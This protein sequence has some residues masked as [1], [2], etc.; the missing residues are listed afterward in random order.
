MPD[1]R[2][3]LCPVSRGVTTGIRPYA[4]CQTARVCTSIV[5]ALLLMVHVQC[6]E[7]VVSC[8]PYWRLSDYR[9]STVCL[10]ETAG[11]KWSMLGG[12]WPRAGGKPVAKRCQPAARA[13]GGAQ[14]SGRCIVVGVCLAT[15]RA[16][17]CGCKMM[18]LHKH[19]MQWGGFMSAIITLSY[20]SRKS[21]IKCS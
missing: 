13:S 19:L 7:K 15:A 18:F 21:P 4:R 14:R 20:M 2:R 11:G 12:K 6:T 8:F 1:H 16:V 17:R 5:R 3:A 9:A 10:L